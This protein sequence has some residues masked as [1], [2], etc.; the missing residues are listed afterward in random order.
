MSI[1]KS[2]SFDD[3][4]RQEYAK[5]P[6]DL[7]SYKR[8]KTIVKRTMMHLAKGT[9]PSPFSFK[10]NDDNE[11]AEVS[12]HMTYLLSKEFDEVTQERY[13]N[14]EKINSMFTYDRYKELWSISVLLM[15]FHIVKSNRVKTEKTE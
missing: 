3:S 15:V 8:Y 13:N 1:L 5:I 4:L 6:S 2:K 12:K 9:S 11:R 7:I 10:Y 14:D